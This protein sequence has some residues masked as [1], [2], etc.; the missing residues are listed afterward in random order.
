MGAPTRQRRHR[1]G[2]RYVGGVY[3]PWGCGRCLSCR[4]GVDVHCADQIGSLLPGG[5]GL[6]RDGGMADYLLVPDAR[7]LVPLPERLNTTVAAALTDVGLTSYHAVRRSQ[8]KLRPGTT[9]VVI[10]AGG[11]GHIGI[12]ILTA[13]TGT[14]VIAVDNRD[15]AR[16]CAV[17]C[18]ADIAVAAEE[19]VTDR[20]WSATRVPRGRRGDRLRRDR[21]DADARGD[22]RQGAR[23][24]HHRGRWRWRTPGLVRRPATRGQR[25]DQPVGISKRTH[26]GARARRGRPDPA[27][28]EAYRLVDAAEAYADLREG[29][30]TGRAVVLP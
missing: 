6:G 21:G 23:R 20:I 4:T 18:G 22:R 25:A 13:V 7:H 14:Q 15:T 11:V 19:D 5:G 10:G 3:G 17:S 9:T 27:D 28:H 12:Q 26:G 16:A 30:V 1:L 8:H 2:D 24:H 29:R